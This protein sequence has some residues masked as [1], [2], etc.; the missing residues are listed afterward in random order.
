MSKSMCAYS[1]WLNI[2]WGK[3]PNP[4]MATYPTLIMIEKIQ[5]LRSI[6]CASYRSGQLIPYCDSSY[7][8]A[9]ET[10][11]GAPLQGVMA[12]EFYKHTQLHP[13]EQPHY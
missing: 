3:V 4:T 9:T 6:C 1:T 11:F 2:L 12:L 13:C 8:C 10:I 5:I 7:N